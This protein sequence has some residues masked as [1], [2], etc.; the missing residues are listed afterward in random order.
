MKVFEAPEDEIDD[1]AY[2]RQIQEREY[3]CQDSELFEHFNYSLPKQMPPTTN[4]P[5]YPRSKKAIGGR[6]IFAHCN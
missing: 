3:Y 1:G 5:K 2:Y 6:T 4:P